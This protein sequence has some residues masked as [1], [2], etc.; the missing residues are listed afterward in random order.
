MHNTVFFIVSPYSASPRQHA[1]VK[2]AVGAFK[3]FKK[4]GNLDILFFFS[5]YVVHN[6]AFMH[7]TSAAPETI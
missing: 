5:A 3:L 4:I 1:V 2:R 7:Y 6:A